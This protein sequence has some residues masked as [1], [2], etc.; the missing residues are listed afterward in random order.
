M[1]AAEGADVSFSWSRGGLRESEAII[2]RVRNT[3]NKSVLTTMTYR[4]DDFD[5]YVC[6]A[7]TAA[8]T[9]QHM[10]KIKHLGKYHSPPTY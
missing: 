6:T 3:G 5:P 7:K 10:I 2:G 1:K 8:T 9:K 4:N